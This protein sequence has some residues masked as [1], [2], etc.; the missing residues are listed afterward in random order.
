MATAEQPPILKITWLTETPV[1]V[2]QWPMT[3]K[4]LQIAEQLVQEQLDVG[5]IQPS[6]SPWNTP[7]FVIAK[8]SVM[9]VPVEIKTDN[10]PAYV[11]QRIAKF[12]PKWGVKHTTR[13]PH[14]STGQAIV[15]RANRTLK[16]YLAKQKQNGNIDLVN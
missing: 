1:W 15:E 10:G 8:K 2:E 3:E 16:E 4:R 12:M 9:G 13:I 7:I 11:S 5:H 14:S 6:V